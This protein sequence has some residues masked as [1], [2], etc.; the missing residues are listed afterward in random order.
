MVIDCGSMM[1]RAGFGGVDEPKYIEPT[2]VAIPKASEIAVDVSDYYIG[3]DALENDPEYYLSSPIE[4]RKIT[5][6]SLMVDL[7]SKLLEDKLDVNP[8]ETRVLLAVPPRTPNDI[9]EQIGTFMFENIEVNALAL[10]DCTQL[11]L[12]ANGRTTGVAVD[13]GYSSVIVA[14]YYEGFRINHAV[15]TMN[16]GGYHIT[17]N[18]RELLESNGQTVSGLSHRELDRIK[19]EHCYVSLTPKS[20]ETHDVLMKQHTTTTGQKIE[21]GAERH[22]A[23]ELLFFPNKDGYNHPYLSELIRNSINHCDIDIRQYLFSNI[24]LSGGSSLFQGLKER[25]LDEIS[26]LIP[27][28]IEVR[29]NAPEDREHSVWIGGSVVTTLEKMVRLWVTREEFQEHGS[30]VIRRLG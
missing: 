10:H 8:Q 15:H 18:L 20:E 23:P 2:I 4:D 7:W 19:K 28:H 21:I 26:R 1:T 16:F 11:V 12:Y 14:P 6:W 25:L 9:K 5:N 29:I 22:L 3:L 30:T 24:I 27:E 17:E 13:M